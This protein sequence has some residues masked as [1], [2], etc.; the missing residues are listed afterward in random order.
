MYDDKNI[1]I[2]FFAKDNPNCKVMSLSVCVY[3]NRITQEVVVEFSWFF[4]KAGPYDK[5]HW[6]R[7]WNYPYIQ[8]WIHI[9]LCGRSQAPPCFIDIR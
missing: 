4:L 5:K 2:Q 3:A 9:F 1:K 8:I 7:L 6:I